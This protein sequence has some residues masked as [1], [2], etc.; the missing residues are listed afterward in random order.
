MADETP[1][2]GTEGEATAPPPEAARPTSRQRR[3]QREHEGEREQR[4]TVAQIRE[5]AGSILGES[6]ALVAAALHRADLDDDEELTR[7]QAMR[8]VERERD[9]PVE[10]TTQ[11]G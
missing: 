11:E 6:V 7:T 5:N 8:Y 9:R 3:A 4:Y 2:T 10:T 1:T